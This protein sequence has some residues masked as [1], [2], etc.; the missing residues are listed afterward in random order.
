MKA[1][2]YFHSEKSDM[3]DNFKELHAPEFLDLTIEAIAEAMRVGY[4]IKIDGDWNL[5][6]GK[7]MA[8][9]LMGMKL[10]DPVEI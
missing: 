10:K 4:E 8:T 6:T 3:E 9:H 5:T 7:F 2:I 1:T